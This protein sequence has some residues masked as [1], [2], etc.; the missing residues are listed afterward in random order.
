MPRIIL[1][2]FIVL[3]IGVS[4][5]A[6]ALPVN[7]EPSYGTNLNLGDDQSLSVNLGFA[8]PFQGSSYSNVFVSSN[9]FISLGGDNGDGCC[10][11]MLHGDTF[12]GIPGFLDGSPRIAPAWFDMV[13]EPDTANNVYLNTTSNRAVITWSNLTEWGTANANTFQVQL[14]ADGSIIF[15]YL[16]LNDT[17]LMNHKALIGIT[18][19]NGALDPGETDLL[20]GSLAG[21]LGTQ[22]MFLIPAGAPGGGLLANSNFNLNNISFTFAPSQGNEPPEVPEPG[23]IGLCAIGMA[24]GLALLRRRGQPARR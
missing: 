7:W 4:E 19:G 24:M 13:S 10:E 1:F 6:S 9:G 23:T 16:A 5:P 18:P 8:F 20:S 17:T 11:G 12:F 21:N 14:L 2:A 22:Y 15:S 3:L